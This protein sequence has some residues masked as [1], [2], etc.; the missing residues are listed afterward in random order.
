MRAT[1]AAFG[2]TSDARILI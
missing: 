2:K 1:F